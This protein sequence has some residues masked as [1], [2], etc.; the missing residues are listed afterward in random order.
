M[1]IFFLLIVEKFRDK[2]FILFFLII[3]TSTCVFKKIFSKTLYIY[4]YYRIEKYFIQDIFFEKVDNSINFFKKI[5][6]NFQFTIFN[7]Q[8]R[9]FYS[10]LKI[11]ILK[12]D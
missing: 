8:T 9:R 2:I 7:F 1:E 12:I 6:G 4:I 11:L 3:K 10:C 5:Y